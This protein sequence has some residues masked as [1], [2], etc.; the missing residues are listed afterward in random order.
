MSSRKAEYS[1][2]TYEEGDETEL[3]LLFNEVYRDYA[4]FVPRT[5]EYWRWS[6]LDRPDVEKEGIIVG[7]HKGKAIAYAVV[8]KSGNI[9]ELCLDPAHQRQVGARLILEKAIEY[10]TR[11]GAESVILNLPSEDLAFRE[12]CEELGLA[13]VSSEKMF[14]SVLDFKTLLSVLSVDKQKRMMDLNESI[15]ICLK[16]APFWISH[17]VW[18]RIENGKTTIEEGIKPYTILMET[19]ASTFTSLIFGTTDPLWALLR[20]RLKIRPL[21]KLNRS[22]R[23]FSL[24][25]LNDPWF[26]PISDY[27]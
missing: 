19:D 21:R 4:G 1:L 24:V 3:T 26:F 2:R 10:L 20:L 12:L 14:L 27:G 18:I 6:C 9:W 22:L 17:H 7:L 8:G 13:K 23:W 25:R 5:L 15:L 16:K 11:V